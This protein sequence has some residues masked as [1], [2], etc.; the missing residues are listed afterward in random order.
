[1]INSL[2]K[3][4]LNSNVS[5]AEGSMISFLENEIK[6]SGLKA[7]F[8]VPDCIMASKDEKFSTET[9]FTAPIDVLGWIA[10]HA[11]TSMISLSTT[12]KIPF[13]LK[14]EFQLVNEENKEFTVT[15]KDNDF[16]IFNEKANLGDTFRFP[17]SIKEDE[18]TLSGHF[19][20]RYALIYLLSE[21]MKS[22]KNSSSFLFVGK[23][24]TNCCREKNAVRRLNPNRLV[25]ISSVESNKTSPIVIK[26]DGKAFSNLSFYEEVLKIAEE[27]GVS[28]AELISTTPITKAQDVV[29]AENTPFLSF[30]LPFQRDGDGKEIIS[31]TTLSNLLRIIK[32]MC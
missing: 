7:S 18:D 31:K 4:L 20:S 12:G 13:E 8:D 25:L 14:E 6:S 11:G 28:L 21:A 9:I 5:G 10:L 22:S 15:K 1:M 29:S 19:I 3:I 2:N 27:I 26:K 23:N 32:E 17:F 30:A 16:L 24:A